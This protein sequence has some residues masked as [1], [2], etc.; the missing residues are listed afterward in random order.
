MHAC[1][2]AQGTGTPD[3]AGQYVPAKHG[4]TV[5]LVDPVGHQYPE[6]QGPEQDTEASAGDE[7]KKPAG[8]GVHT[9]APPVLYWP[10]GQAIAVAFV[11]PTGQMKPP[12]QGPE[13]DAEGSA[14]DEP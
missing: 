4:I 2:A 5:A 8:Q 6:A 10:T 7:P 13:Q 14:G 11:D 3:P 9:D 1:P 12:L